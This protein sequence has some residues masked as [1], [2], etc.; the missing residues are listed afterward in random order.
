M[1]MSAP[2]STNLPLPQQGDFE[3][4]Y[5]IR[6]HIDT[7]LCLTHTHPHT[8]SHT[9]N[10]HIFDFQTRRMASSVGDEENAAELE[11]GPEF[12]SSNLVQCLSNDEVFFLLCKK[13]E[14][15]GATGPTME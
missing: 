14:N 4:S 9:N 10:N 13:K 11:F 15:A 3:T 2:F 12:A 8:L 6:T 1:T 5:T 7:L